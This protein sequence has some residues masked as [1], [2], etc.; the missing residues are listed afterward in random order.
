[1]IIEIAIISLARRNGG[2]KI[3]TDPFNPMF[4]ARYPLTLGYNMEVDL[5]V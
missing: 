4:D 3:P 2:Y 5:N 1:M